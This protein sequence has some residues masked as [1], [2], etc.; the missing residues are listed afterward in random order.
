M[1]IY[2]KLDNIWPFITPLRKSN[3]GQKRI[4][5]MQ[6]FIWNKLTNNLSILSTAT[7]FTRNHKGLV[8][9]ILE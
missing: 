4:L 7:S 3:L 6:P 2:I 8:L 9:K 5:F 1:Y